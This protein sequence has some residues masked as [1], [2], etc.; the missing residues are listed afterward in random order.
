MF[1][2][3]IPW[4]LKNVFGCKQT[5]DAKA[6]MV[7]PSNGAGIRRELFSEENLTGEDIAKSGSSRIKL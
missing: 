5:A 4:N 2:S 3:L 1:V 6:R 7:E